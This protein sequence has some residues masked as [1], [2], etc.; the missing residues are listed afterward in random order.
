MPFTL[1]DLLVERSPHHQS[2]KWSG[3]EEGSIVKTFV[4]PRMYRSPYIYLQGGW[5]THGGKATIAPVPLLRFLGIWDGCAAQ[6][7]FPPLIRD[8]VGVRLGSS[9]LYGGGCFQRTTGSWWL[10]DLVGTGSPTSYMSIGERRRKNSLKDTRS[11]NTC[12]PQNIL[13][14]AAAGSPLATA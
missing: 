5:H 2:V 7:S 3:E 9:K 10:A 12:Q 11:D 1:A 4:R 6:T 13:S 8:G 14:A